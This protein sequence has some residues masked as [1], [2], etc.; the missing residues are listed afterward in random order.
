MGVLD[1]LIAKQIATADDLATATGYDEHVIGIFF[2][3]T[4]LSIWAHSFLKARLMRVAC[5][6]LFCEEIDE[7]RYRANHI[8]SLLVTPGW[9][10]ALQWSETFYPI[11][12]DIRRFLSATTFGRLKDESTPSAFEFTHGKT[13]WKYL[14]ESP[15]QRRNFDLWMRER[16][17]HEES[18]W[19]TRFPPC[20]SLSSASLKKDPEAVLLVDVGG[21]SGSQVID[22]KAQFPHLP[23]RTVLQD[24]F[25]PKSNELPQQSEGLEIMAYDLLTPQPLKGKL[26]SP[27]PNCLTPFILLLRKPAV[28]VPGSTTFATFSTTGQTK[29]VLI[30][31]NK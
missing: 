24:L 30:S 4:K 10:G 28:Q 26:L 18:L 14:E 15:H 29:N 2:Y 7:R 22:F 5:A 16:R 25:P 1:A 21:A 23:G 11:L 27:F 31:Y 17:K 12:A 9:K 8:T 20:V 13:I 3:P 6:L 19:H